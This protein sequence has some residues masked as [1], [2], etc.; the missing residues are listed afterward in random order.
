MRSTQHDIKRSPISRVML[1]AGG[2]ILLALTTA[3]CS[4]VNMTGFSMPVFGLTKKSK[5]E[6][7]LMA[8]AAISSEEGASAKQPQGRADK[9]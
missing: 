2:P 4:A 1:L 7:D 3:G 8:T 6:T 9:Y 5:A